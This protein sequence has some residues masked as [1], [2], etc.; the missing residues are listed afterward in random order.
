[1]SVKDCTVLVCYGKRRR[2]VKL[3]SPTFTELRTN[4]LAEFADILPQVPV[5]ELNLLFQV[6][7]ESW[8]GEFIDIVNTEEAIQDRCIVRMIVEASHS[9]QSTV[10]VST[11]PQVCC[12]VM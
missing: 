10:S 4:V 11:A 2:P 1:M 8:G 9:I 12:Y 3:S 6:K 5:S 7:D